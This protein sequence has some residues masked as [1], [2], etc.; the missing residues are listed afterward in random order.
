[1]GFK[2]ISNVQDELLLN[3][4]TQGYLDLHPSADAEIIGQEYSNQLMKRLQ[5]QSPAL[6]PE[7]DAF[8]KTPAGER[9][10]EWMIDAGI[11]LSLMD[12]RRKIWDTCYQDLMENEKN[13][14][15]DQLPLKPYG[16]SHSGLKFQ[17]FLT[18]SKILTF[19]SMV[20]FIVLT[21]LWVLGLVVSTVPLIVLLVTV[22]TTVTWFFLKKSWNRSFGQE[23]RKHSEKN[24]ANKLIWEA[25]FGGVPKYSFKKENWVLPTCP[26]SWADNKEDLK[27]YS[28][29]KEYFTAKYVT[30]YTEQSMPELVLPETGVSV[31]PVK[32]LEILR[33]QFKNQTN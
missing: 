24:E 11:L 32:E 33:D 31:L 3:I 9:H 2:T 8:L 28:K 27:E 1:M 13:N 4:L 15:S 19:L 16:L 29:V 25:K 23:I 10:V 7:W 26:F 12:V 14:N 18:L 21:V 6:K 22:V 30:P 20:S 5:E 17:R